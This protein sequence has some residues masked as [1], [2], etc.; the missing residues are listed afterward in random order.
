[1]LLSISI[2]KYLITALL[3]IILVLRLP[4]AVRL[5]HL[6]PPDGR[7]ILESLDLVLALAEDGDVVVDH[8]ILRTWRLQLQKDPT[9][10]LKDFFFFEARFDIADVESC[11]RGQNGKGGGPMP[12]LFL[13]PQAFEASLFV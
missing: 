13:K 6:P 9:L 10:L 8:S 12:P 7:G 5:L 11:P 2:N 3:E 1:M 4:A